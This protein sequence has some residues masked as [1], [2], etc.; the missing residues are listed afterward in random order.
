M[1]W[2]QP[3]RLR[4]S[5][6]G[7][8]PVLFGCPP[9]S[10]CGTPAYAARFSFCRGVSAGS[11]RMQ[12]TRAVLDE[13]HAC[14]RAVYVCPLAPDK[15]AVRRPIGIARCLVCLSC[16]FFVHAC[17]YAYSFAGAQVLAARDG[18]GIAGYADGR[19]AGKGRCGIATVRPSVVP[20]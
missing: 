2:R 13:L 8:C 7:E 14:T 17:L 1:Y 5:L 11:E 10:S 19:K 16:G 4:D 3:F 18:V 20:A 9:V 15:V 12:G 6:P